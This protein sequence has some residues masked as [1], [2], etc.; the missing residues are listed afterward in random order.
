MNEFKIAC[1][2]DVMLGDSF[3]AIGQGV[4]SSL[5]KYGKDFLPN[6]IVDVLQNHDLVLCNIECVLSDVGR[7][8]YSLRSLHMRGQPE[9]ARH[10]MDWGLTVAN[11]ANNHIL[12][13]GSEAALDT[14]WQLEHVGIN[15]VWFGKNRVFQPGFQINSI[16]LSN[17]VVSVFGMCFLEEK[18]AYY[19][20]AELKELLDSIGSLTRRGETVIVTVHWGKELMDRPSIKQ[21]QIAQQ[22]VEAGASLIIGH[23]PHVV[24]GIEKVNDSL[25]AYS[26]GNFIFD[27]FLDCTRWSVILSV[28][29]SGKEISRWDYIPI[30]RDKEHRPKFA[31]G[32]REIEL[33]EEIERR[34]YLLQSEMPREQYEKQYDSEFRMLNSIA[35]HKLWLELAKRMPTLKF[36][37]WPQLLL[38][39]IQRRLGI[40]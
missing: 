31:K 38:R 34:C 26:L 25:V 15:T 19:G 12:E 5:D 11:V 14:I 13:Q 39:P 21:R 7:K 40:W 2:G 1:V 16:T 28:T 27:S 33:R 18:Y 36:I 4:A 24:Q 29:M 32:I 37:Y 6:E 3:Y 22:L 8:E 30:E 35:R 17:Q 20:G 9:S 10:L 23:H